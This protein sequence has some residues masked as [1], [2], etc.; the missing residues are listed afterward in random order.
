MCALTDSVIEVEAVVCLCSPWK[1]FNHFRK[2]AGSDGKGIRLP[3][4]K[5]AVE[6]SGLFA[7]NEAVEALFKEL[8]LNP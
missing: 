1:A 6:H 8:D 7:T 2:V 4:F 5:V 3:A